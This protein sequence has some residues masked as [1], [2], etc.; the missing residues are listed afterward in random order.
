[1]SNKSEDDR[2]REMNDE[3]DTNGVAITSTTDGWVLMLT[4]AKLLELLE[5]SRAHGKIIIFI[6]TPQSPQYLD[7]TKLN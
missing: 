1:M 6:K 4:Q 5:K 7:T 2:V 3:V